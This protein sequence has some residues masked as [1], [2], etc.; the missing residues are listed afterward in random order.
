V[1][2][3]CVAKDPSEQQPSEGKCPQTYHV[4]SYFIIHCPALP[5]WNLRI[6]LSV[7]TLPLFTFL[8]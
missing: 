7:F 6:D 8:G 5:Y 1:V 3:Q 2:P 4:L